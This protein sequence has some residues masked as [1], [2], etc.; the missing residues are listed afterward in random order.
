MLWPLESISQPRKTIIN[1]AL[2]GQMIWQ[3]PIVNI[4]LGGRYEINDEFDNSFVPRLALTRQFD[5][6]YFKALAARAFRPPTM[7]NTLFN[8][9]PLNQTDYDGLSELQPEESTILELETGIDLTE[10]SQ[11]IVTLFDIKIKDPI[12]YVYESPNQFPTYVNEEETGSQGIELQ[13]NNQWEKY[14]SKL[15]YSY[16]R[17]TERS[18]YYAAESEDHQF[19]GLPQH[20]I[21]W[22]GGTWLTENIHWSLNALWRSSIVGHGELNPATFT[23]NEMSLD[24]SLVLNTWVRFTGL[25]EKM[26]LGFGIDNL[27][28]ENNPVAAGSE[29]FIRP[30]PG[31][32]RTFR[33]QL[34]YQF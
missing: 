1:H 25:H 12:I 34:K 33:L 11:F 21:S 5:R 28:D 24:D 32:G 9:I 20:K 22:T 4:T 3:N 8:G 6:I 30:L 17:A 13:L 10:H 31:L 27:T 16:Y 29:G 26:E 19:L 2:Y 23:P 15:S 7:A 18:T 14:S